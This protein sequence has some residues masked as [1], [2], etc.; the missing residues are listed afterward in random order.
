VGVERKE[1]LK[2]GN[3]NEKAAESGGSLMFSLPGVNLSH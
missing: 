1:A 3:F 2:K